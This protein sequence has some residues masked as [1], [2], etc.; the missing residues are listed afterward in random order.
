[1]NEERI[2]QSLDKIS[3]DISDLKVVVGKQEENIKEHMRRTEI[4]EENLA[5]IR[6]EI[7]PLKNHVVVINGVLKIVGIVAII[8]G[9]A[10]SVFKIIETFISIVK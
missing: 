9:A 7:E 10:A 8:I 2:F 4:A 3:E 6:E 5:L 1:M